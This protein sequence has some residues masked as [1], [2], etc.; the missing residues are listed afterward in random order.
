MA[1]WSA[2][3]LVQRAAHQEETYR[4]THTELLAAHEKTSD[5]KI[6]DAVAWCSHIGPCDPA[7]AQR[8]VRIAERLVNQQRNALH[9]ETLGVTLYRAGRFADSIKVLAERVKIHKEGGGSYTWLFLALAHKRLGHHEEARQWFDKF[10]AW[11]GK[12]QFK[13]WQERLQWQRLHQEAKALVSVPP[14]MPRVA[15]G[16]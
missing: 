2:L 8:A 9:L 13:T 6:A 1:V 10:A 7:A 15:P 3:L 12:Q 11:Y 14:P 5:A 16:N 4:Q